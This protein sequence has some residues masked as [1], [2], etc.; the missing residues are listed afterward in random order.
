MTDRPILFTGA[1]VRALLAG[2]KTQTRRLPDIPEA[3]EILD[4]VKV[5]TD[6]KTGRSVYEMKDK[7]GKHVHIR[8]GKRSTTTQFMPPIAVGDRLWVRETVACGECAK[9]PPSHWA[10][11][12]WRREQGT[13]EN[14]NG[15]WYQ[16][17]D[18][19]PAR[20]ICG[21]GRWV[22]GIHM[23][24]W[25]SRLTLLVTDVRIERLQAISEEDAIAEGVEPLHGGFFPY[26]LTTFMTTFVGEREVPAQYCQ[27]ARDSYERLWDFINGRGSWATNPWVIA[28]TFTV[29]LGNIDAYQRS[30]ATGSLVTATDV[31]NS[32]IEMDI[33]SWKDHRP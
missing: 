31:A 7:A 10:P 21:P 29:Q 22:P 4:F 9:G 12:F 15:L 5:A 26:G 30:P 2:R 14:P 6:N 17:D 19:A 20:P 16:A 1:M 18:L 23:P 28:Y 13:P 32:R 24:R 8:N 11:S 33:P 25:V 27:Y 3:G